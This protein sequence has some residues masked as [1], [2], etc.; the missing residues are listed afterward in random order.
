MDETQALTKQVAPREEEGKP[1]SST[2]TSAGAR[3]VTKP[4]MPCTHCSSLTSLLTPCSLPRSLGAPTS[5]PE[6][7]CPVGS[8]VVEKGTEAPRGKQWMHEDTSRDNG[9]MVTAWA[10]L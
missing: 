3:K 9:G 1:Q 7:G 4:A 6:G 2:Q 8:H 5:L 10:E